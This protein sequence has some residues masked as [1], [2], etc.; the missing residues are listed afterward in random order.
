ME[1]IDD[2]ASAVAHLM[3]RVS[4]REMM[5]LY[6]VPRFATPTEFLVLLAQQRGKLK[7]VRAR[8]GR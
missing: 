7:K 1:N 5:R 8:P 3:T 6:A 2:P 4:D